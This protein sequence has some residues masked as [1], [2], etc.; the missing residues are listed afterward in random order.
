M[1]INTTTLREGYRHFVYPY[2][3][4]LQGAITL[5]L[6]LSDQI[7]TP[8]LNGLEGQYRRVV[9]L[10]DEKLD[11]TLRYFSVLLK[12][13]IYGNHSK[14]KNKRH[15]ATPLLILTREGGGN[16]GQR[17][18]L[19]GAI[20]NVP[21]NKVAHLPD[22]VASAWAQCDFSNKQVCV[23]PINDAAGWLNYITKQ[24]RLKNEDLLDLKTLNIP[25]FI[26]QRI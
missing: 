24:V 23:K 14:H 22:I 1:S 13:S 15:W 21:A 16:S 4:H 26:Q 8:Y 25:Q 5:T 2:S 11:K 12:A 6:K 9:R 10:D 20:G 19:H 3:E 18:H 17:L 7:S